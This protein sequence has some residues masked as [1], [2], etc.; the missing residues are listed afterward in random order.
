MTDVAVDD[1]K[2]FA[3]SRKS[4]EQQT[5]KRIGNIDHASIGLATIVKYGRKIDRIFVLDKAGFLHERFVFFV[6]YV[7]QQVVACK[8]GYSYAG[9]K[10][11]KI[12]AKQREGIECRADSRAAR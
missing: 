2:C 1:R 6:E 3:G 9:S 7:V 8:A 12:A 10:Q 11:Q 4:D 5:P